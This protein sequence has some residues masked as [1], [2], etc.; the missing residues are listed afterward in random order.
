MPITR[1]EENGIACNKQ[2]ELQ[3]THSPQKCDNYPGRGP[4]SSSERSGA[5]EENTTGRVN[6]E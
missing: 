3:P 2:H 5:W 4:T 6:Q 1:R